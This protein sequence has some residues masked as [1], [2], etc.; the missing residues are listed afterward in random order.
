MEKWREIGGYPA[1]EV[2]DQGR[3]RSKRREVTKGVRQVLPERFLRLRPVGNGYRAVSLCKD[4]VARNYYVHALVL[5]AF[6]GEAPPNTEA[7]HYDGDKTN[8]KL[9]N[10]RWDT[11]SSNRADSKRLGVRLGGPHMA[12]E[13]HPNAKLTAVAVR[14][15]RVAIP[16]RGYRKLLAK[17]F[18]CSVRTISLI[19]AGVAWR[20]I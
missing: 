9:S 3:I 8:N 16:V 5:R 19:R 10:L 1:Y 14:E 6:V 13:Q 18:G 7:C 17:K 2:S 4:G 11:R 20:E 15:V 12:G